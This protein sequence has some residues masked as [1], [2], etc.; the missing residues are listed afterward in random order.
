MIT[1][2]LLCLVFLG[3]GYLIGIWLR[4]DRLWLPYALLYSY[5]AYLVSFYLVSLIGWS[6]EAMINIQFGQLIILLAI[7]FLRGDIRRLYLAWKLSF[8]S[9]QIIAI[10]E[11]VVGLVV[12]IWLSLVGPYLEIPT[13]VFE[14]LSRITDIK[15]SMKHG[16]FSA[17]FPWYSAVAIALSYSGESIRQIIFPLTIALTTIFL[18]SIVSFARAIAGSTA[19]SSI[20]LWILLVASPVFTALLFGTSV[21]SYLRYYVFAPAFLPYLIYLLVGLVVVESMV[22]RRQAVSLT[23]TA[24]TTALGLF[25]SYIVHRQE[26]LFIAVLVGTAVAYAVVV[27]LTKSRKS[28]TGKLSQSLGIWEIAAVAGIPILLVCAVLLKFKGAE[29]ESFLLINNVIDVGKFIGLDREFLI[30]D[31]FGRVFETLGV[32]ALILFASYFLFIPR[33]KRSSFLSF[34]IVVPILIVFNPISVDIFLSVSKQEV[35][36]RF[37]YMTPIGLVAGYLFAYLITQG[38]AQKYLKRNVAIAVMLLVSLIPFKD[39][40]D[41]LQ[42]RYGTLL[43]ISPLQDIRLYSDLLEEVEKYSD[44]DLLTDP[45]TG[46]VIGALTQNKYSGFKFH[47]SGD[48]VDLNKNEYSDDS[49]S[50]FRNR[51]VIVN[52]RDGAYSPNG[53]ISGHWPHSI[54]KTSN[55]YSRPLRE[56]LAT[57]PPHF[58]LLWEKDRIRL[59]EIVNRESI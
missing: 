31:P 9:R 11:L 4:L 2:L 40:Q 24:T 18:L 21:F 15:G 44:R 49:F 58:N 23:E 36:W 20:G 14:H 33:D 8:G 39:S 29:T 12:T 13:D 53:R 22:N 10:P 45:V 27:T 16:G 34:S 56:F 51:L 47:H 55:Y 35:L 32:G 26:A 43:A 7:L 52:L 54:L 5:A 38:A 28:R 46:Y 3:P 59:Y 30:A 42:Q 6:A 17:S 1:T 48:H 41:L 19:L 37:M 25:V 50:G 57:N